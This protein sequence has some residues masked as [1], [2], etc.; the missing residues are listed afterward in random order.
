MTPVEIEV[1]IHYCYL[2]D[3]HPRAEVPSVKM[4][5]SMWMEEGMI[6]PLTHEIT[7]KGRVLVEMLCNTPMPVETWVDPRIKE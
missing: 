5:L 3:N 4:A 1:L 6:N 2:P 7:K